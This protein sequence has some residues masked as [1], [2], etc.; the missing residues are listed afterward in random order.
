MFL[1]IFKYSKKTAKADSSELLFRR[2]VHTRYVY[3]IEA[4]GTKDRDAWPWPAVALVS[5]QASDRQTE[6]IDKV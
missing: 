6:E 3:C 2:C 4:F 5:G 1:Y